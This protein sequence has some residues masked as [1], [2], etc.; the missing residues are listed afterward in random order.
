MVSI[1]WCR[2]KASKRPS[3]VVGRK[4]TVL[5]GKVLAQLD[6]PA[7]KRGEACL[8]N[9]AKQIVGGIF[10][11]HDGL[12]ILALRDPVAIEWHVAAERIVRALG[13]IDLAPAV[14][15]DLCLGEIGEGWPLQRL[16]FERPME[17]LVLAECLGMVGSRMGET[18]THLN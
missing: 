12:G 11:R 3:V 2:K 17:A 14:E 6:G 16:G 7:E 9:A 5:P 1:F 13:V 18:D 4:A 10:E 15:N 8:I